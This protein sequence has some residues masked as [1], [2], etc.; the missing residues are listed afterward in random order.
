[1]KMKSRDIIEIIAAFAVAWIFYQGLV[2]ATGTAL[3]IVSVVSDS[4]YHGEDF[5]VWWEKHA[6]Y[7]DS[8]DID[9]ETFEQFILSNGVSKG[10]MLFVVHDEFLEVGDIAIYRKSPNDIAIVHRIVDIDQNKV[11]LKGDRN[12]RFDDPILKEQI[13]GKVVF[14]VPLLGYP[15]IF[16]NLFGI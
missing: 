3:P 15:R 6:S 13:E 11:I 1:M 4:M 2:F 8:N 9:K 7:Y 14:G 5:D 10:D 12:I 16:L